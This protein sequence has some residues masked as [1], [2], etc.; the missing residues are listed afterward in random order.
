MEI[1]KKLFKNFITHQII[2][3]TPLFH[4]SFCW[5]KQQSKRLWNNI[6]QLG[7][8]ED[9]Q[10]YFLGYII[11]K[12]NQYK[13]SE[14]V[15][16]IS[17]I[18]G[19]QRLISLIL[20]ICNLCNSEKVEPKNKQLLYNN[21][22]INNDNAKSIKLKVKQKD[23]QTLRKIIKSTISTQQPLFNKNDSDN[24]I[25]T[26]TYFNKKLKKTNNNTIIKGLSKIYFI[27]ISLDE[28]D[29]AQQIYKSMNSTQK[30]LN[31]V[32]ITRNHIF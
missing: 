5:S 26:Y 20:L 30:Y 14:I 9:E 29:D 21:F 17:I 24:I 4:R 2:I 32:D 31:S 28:E 12:K 22:I 8:N 18:D 19:Q 3:E 25:N 15:Q 6:K 11:F 27:L 10:E 1:E 7:V 13:L 16:K 23:E